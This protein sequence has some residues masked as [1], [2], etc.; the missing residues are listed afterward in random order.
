MNLRE[1]AAELVKR[2]TQ[3]QGIPPKANTKVLAR[4]AALLGTTKR[5][6]Q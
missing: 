2:S 6:K 5:E 3:T 4:V 1:A